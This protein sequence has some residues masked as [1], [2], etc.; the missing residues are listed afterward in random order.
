MKIAIVTD[1]FGL[2]MLEAMACGLPVAAYPVTGPIDVV[3]EGVTGVLSQDLC[4][5]SLSA[6]DIVHGTASI[7]PV[8]ARGV[9]VPSCL[10]PAWN[11][12]PF[13]LIDCVSCRLS[14]ANPVI[15][16]HGTNGECH[17]SKKSTQDRRL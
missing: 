5:A 9:T 17:A 16:C 12:L 14:G 10:F 6:L 15:Q 4:E 2:V 7:M 11:P 3:V 8:P 1:T 13:I